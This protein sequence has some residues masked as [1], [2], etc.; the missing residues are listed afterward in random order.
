MYICDEQNIVMYNS[1]LHF[2]MQCMINVMK[3]APSYS[4]NMDV[5]AS[6]AACHWLDMEN[7]ERK[8]GYIRYGYMI[9]QRSF[10]VCIITYL[11]LDKPSF[12]HEL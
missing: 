11:C 7:Q 8:S 6:V 4:L 3:W 10:L 12:G 2:V 5:P 1:G 9:T